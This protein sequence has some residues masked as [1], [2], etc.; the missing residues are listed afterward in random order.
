M[1]DQRTR[2]KRT[3]TIEIG[4]RGGTG[5]IADVDAIEGVRTS[6]PFHKRW[7]RRR[8]RVL[9]VVERAILIAHHEVQVAC[10]RQ[11]T[12]STSIDHRTQAERAVAVDVG[13]RGGAPVADVDTIEGVL[14][15]GPLLENRRRRCPGILDVVECATPF[16]H[17]EVHVACERQKRVSCGRC[18]SMDAV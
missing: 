15:S 7:R 10:E 6:G 11:K 5:T 18:R 9:H 2:S 14:T 17:H 3:I 4:E 1:F 12:F 16:A 13:K 8:P